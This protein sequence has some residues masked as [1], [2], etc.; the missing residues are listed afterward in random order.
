MLTL[1]NYL[2]L[3]SQVTIDNYTS[4]SISTAI[5]RANSIFTNLL[6]KKY[7]ELYSQ[8]YCK[9]IRLVEY[10]TSGQTE[11]TPIFGID[12]GEDILLYKNVKNESE[13][14]RATALNTSAVTETKITLTAADALSEGDTVTAVYYHT[15]DD[16]TL[17]LTYTADITTYYVIKESRG[18]QF[19][20]DSEAGDEIYLKTIMDLIPDII[21]QTYEQLEYIGQVGEIGGI[22]M[23]GL[24]RQ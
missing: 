9:Y 18:A 21:S 6:H 15:E 14:F 7:Y 11:I 22:E 3:Q 24:D 12:T 1:S 8:K 20:F 10:A 4:A 17:F 2:T 13:L 23:I 16:P 19:H 5:E